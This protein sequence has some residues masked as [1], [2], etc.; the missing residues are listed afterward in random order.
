M[1]SLRCGEMLC[2]GDVFGIEERRRRLDL[3]EGTLDGPVQQ[4]RRCGESAEI[5]EDLVAEVVGVDDDGVGVVRNARHRLGRPAAWCHRLHPADD[6]CE[7]DDDQLVLRPRVV[8]QAGVVVGFEDDVKIRCACEE[9]V[10]VGGDQRPR[11]VRAGAGVPVGAQLDQQP[12]AVNRHGRVGGRV[13]A[14]ELAVAQLVDL[15]VEEVDSAA[16]QRP[17][18]A[19]CAVPRRRDEHVGVRRA[20][21]RLGLRRAEF[22][23]ASV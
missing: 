19:R 2:D 16:E 21:Q 7:C 4:S 5:Q 9:F 17:L 22:P 1:P 10:V 11:P 8:V 20:E 14:D 15:V 3:F 6:V 23:V 13:D 12:V 18:E